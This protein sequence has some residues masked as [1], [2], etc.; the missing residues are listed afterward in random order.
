MDLRA[1]LGIVVG[2]P[3]GRGA[4]T[5]IEPTP[6]AR[7]MVASA[8]RMVFEQPDEAS[9]RDQCTRVIAMFEPRMSAVAR[10]LA[11]AEPDLLSHFTFPELH[12]ARIRSPNPQERLN[13]EI[14]RRTAVVGIFLRVLLDS[15]SDRSVGRCR[16]VPEGPRVT[17][18]LSVEPPGSDLVRA[19]PLGPRGWPRDLIAA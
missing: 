14:K 9:A 2:A 11:D 17:R 6:T 1:I 7:S 10:L 18:N 12:R 5:A 13:K 15:G 19:S 4:C 16:M 3:T 8:I